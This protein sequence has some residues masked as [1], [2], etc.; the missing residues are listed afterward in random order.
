LWEVKDESDQVHFGQEA[1]KVEVLRFF[2]SFYQDST[3]NTIEDQIATVRLYPRMVF[4][5]EVILLEKP[6]T[7]EEVLD[8]L[9]GLTKYKN[10]RPDRWTV[11]FF[12]HFF[13]LVAKDLL[14]AVKESCLSR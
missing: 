9:K 7:T 1:I 3:L 2:R 4:E 11:E 12:L 5:E 10:P 8:V 6:C 13:D 14:E